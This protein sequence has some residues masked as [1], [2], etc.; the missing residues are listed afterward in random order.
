MSIILSYYRLPVAER[1]SVTQD[2]ALWG[3]FRKRLQKAQSEALHSTLEEMDKPGGSREE[4]FA[5]FGSLMEERRDPRHF[6]MEKD[7]H[8]IGYLLTGESEIRE[9]HRN[10]APLHNVIFGGV[11]TAMT[12]GYGAVRYYE[13]VLVADS[14]QALAKAV[15]PEP[16]LTSDLIRR[17]WRS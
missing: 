16:L 13:G 5:R 10:G 11:S 6:N 4:R 2:E 15:H 12:T 1:K 14:A 8:T 9:E 7:W 17:E 3:Q